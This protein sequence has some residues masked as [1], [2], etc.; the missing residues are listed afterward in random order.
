MIKTCSINVSEEDMGSGGRNSSED[1]MADPF[2]AIALTLYPQMFPGHLGQ[3]RM[4]AALTQG[5][6]SCEAVNIRDF[7]TDKHRSVDD[8]PAGGGPGMVLRADIIAAAVDDVTARCPTL[9]ILAMTPR[10]TPITQARVRRLAKGGGA[11][12]LCGRFEGF[13]ERLFIARPTIESICISDIVLSGGEIAALMLFEACI[14]LRPGLMG[15][16]TS[17]DDESFEHGLLEYPHYT[18][19]AEWE[20][21]KIPDSLRNGNHATITAWRSGKAEEDTKNRRP[22]MWG[23]VVASRETNNNAKKIP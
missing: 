19:P 18:R 8:T 16:S 5:L 9:P 10:G 2:V 7:A 22:D 6:W 13:D 15:T 23:R 4:G 1:S 17:G 14:R 20:G 21:H 12:I 11:I 3:A